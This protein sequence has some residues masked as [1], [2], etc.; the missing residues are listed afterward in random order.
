VQVYLD[1]DE[2]DLEAPEIEPLY[3]WLEQNFRVVLPDYADSSLTRSETLIKQCEA[4]LIF[5]GQASGLWLK[6]R[7]LALQKTIYERPRPL[8]AK[9]IYLAD[10]TKQP[11]SDSD[12]P[13]IKGFNGF[14]PELLNAFLE[15][16]T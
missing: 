7:L 2:R 1:C 13:I 4:V 12:V 10:S 11:L 14:Q 3:E 6:R 15:Q 9:A 16:L 8:R 5:Y